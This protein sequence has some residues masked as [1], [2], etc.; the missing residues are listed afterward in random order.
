MNGSAFWCA[1][2]I[3]NNEIL[4]AFSL[5]QC[6]GADI[7]RFSNHMR[8][9]R[10]SVELEVFVTPHKTCKYIKKA[11]NARKIQIIA[12]IRMTTC[13]SR[14]KNSGFYNDDSD[15]RRNVVTTGGTRAPLAPTRLHAPFS[16][17]FHS[18]RRAATRLYQRIEGK[19]GL[20]LMR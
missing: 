10:H 17:G 12:V 4:T 19:F 14:A 11:K 16:Q 20:R 15:F 18:L 2:A 13:K 5:M 6:V 3:T 1:Y 9:Q 8:P 7:L